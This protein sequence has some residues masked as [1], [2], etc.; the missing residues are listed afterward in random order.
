MP[1]T[2]AMNRPETPVRD[3]ELFDAYSRTVVHVAETVSP[4]VVYIEV[5][6]AGS[7]SG[8]ILAPDGYILTNSHVVHNAREIAVTLHDGRTIK[9]ELIGEDPSTDLA[10]LRID[11]PNLTPARLADSQM[12]RVGQL[13][14]A[15]GNPYGFQTSVTTGVVSA[16]G[17]SLR[18]Y[19]GRNIDNVL[20]TDAALNPGNSGGPLV[21]SRGEV[22]GVNTAV[23]L[24]AQGLCFAI[25]INTAKWVASRLIREGRV[26]RSQIGIQGQNVVLPRRLSQLHNL[27]ETGVRVAG[28][29]PNS[30]AFRSSLKEGDVIIAFDGQPVLGIDD[31]HRLL[32]EDRVGTRIPLTVLRKGEK[33][34]VHLVP[35]EA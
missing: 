14:I 19:S 16:L 34:I 28:I 5:K 24:P 31:L 32:T 18:S 15:I 20:Q 21:D 17:R 23:I 11:A 25:A 3:D 8:F 22:I 12:V 4:S 35:G 30:P 10:V 33:E 26:R 2:T 9:A 7:G 27:G 6:G 29:E 1:V 13:A